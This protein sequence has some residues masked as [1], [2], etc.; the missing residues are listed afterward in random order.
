MFAWILF[1]LYPSR[2]PVELE[3]LSTFAWILFD[4]FVEFARL[5]V[6]PLGPSVYVSASAML[7]R[8]RRDVKV[9]RGHKQ[10]IGLT[11][12]MAG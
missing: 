12:T 3:G 7:S 11:L 6:S 5:R 9:V 1:D 10:V 2:L 8:M 4:L